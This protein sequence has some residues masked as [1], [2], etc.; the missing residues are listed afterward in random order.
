MSLESSTFTNLSCHEPS[1]PSGLYCLSLDPYS[2]ILTTYTII[3]IL[4]LL[5]LCILVL[6]K[7][8]QRWRQHRFSSSASTTSHSDSY[9]YH[10]VTIEI[11]H[12]IGCI[13]IC[14]G[15]YT[16]NCQMLLVWF[17]LFSFTWFSE[18]C[19]HILTCVEHYM[20]VVHP[21]TYLSLRKEKGIRIRNMSIICSWLLCFVGACLT[22]LENVSLIMLFCL[23]TLSLVITSF[24]CLSVL[25]ALIRPGPG[26]QSGERARVDQS[27]KR[28]FY[29][30]VAILGVL[31]LRCT[32]NLS[33]AA[34][35][36]IKS[37][38]NECVLVSGDVWFSI[39]SSLVLP[40]LFLQKVGT[41]ACSKTNIK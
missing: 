9:T 38:I 4:F 1:F 35:Y 26:E 25:C 23:L 33:W 12:M 3:N 22:P 27:K 2:L 37:K 20:A 17:Y 24:C 5:P 28:A 40:L 8:L 29:I 19:F 14:G 31:F 15:S 16:K 32:W 10:L 7:G 36:M 11:I 21:I 18:T 34:L 39:P 41:F 6:Y 13:L 30:I